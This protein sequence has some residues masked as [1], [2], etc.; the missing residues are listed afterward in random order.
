MLIPPSIFIVMVVCSVGVAV[1]GVLGV[2]GHVVR[3]MY[4]LC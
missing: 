4:W 3:A 1:V 2:G